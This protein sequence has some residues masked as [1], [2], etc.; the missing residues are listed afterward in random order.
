MET[1]VTQ[2]LIDR[3][4]EGDTSLEEESQLRAYF[5][6]PQIDPSLKSVQPMFAYFEQAKTETTT[7][8]EN[9]N[10]PKTNRK[11]SFWKYAVAAVLVPA[12]IWA[13]VSFYQ[14][15]TEK[16]EAEITYQQVK[17]AL[18]TISAN[19]NKGAEKVAYLK[20]FETTTHKIIKNENFN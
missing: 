6:S 1:K 3:Y 2:Q 4:L 9:Q 15:Q 14:Q 8:L 20:T 5:N 13:G 11:I 19:Y 16:K 10:K 17:N 18:E 7:V 12:C